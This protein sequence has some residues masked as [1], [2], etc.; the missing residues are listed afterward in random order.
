VPQATREDSGMKMVPIRDQARTLARVQVDQ[1]G[2][3]ILVIEDQRSLALL[4]ASMLHDRWGCTVHVAHTLAEARAHLAAESGYL[5]AICDLHLPDAEHGEVIDPVVR[6]GVPAIAVTAAFGDEMRALILK[7]GVVDYV[8]KD[9]INAYGY[10]CDLIGRLSRN[11]SIKVLAVDDSASIRAVLKQAL[12]MYSLQVLLASD[13]A[14]GLAL[15]GAHPEI[16]V[17]LVDCLMP[18]MDGF[19]LTIEARKLHGKDR[20]AIIGMSGSDD[21]MFSA[22]FLKNGANDF[23]RKPFHFEEVICRVNQN[24]EVLELIEIAQNAANRDFLTGLFNRRYF[25]HEGRDRYSSARG[26]R[27]NVAAAMLDLD[28]FKQ[29]NDRFGHER[30]DLVLRATAKCIQQAFPE[31]LPA[32]LGGEEFAILCIDCTPTTLVQRLERL[33]ENIAAMQVEACDFGVTVSMGL[34]TAGHPE[35]S[36][37]VMLRRAD[38]FLYQAKQGGRNRLVHDL[39]PAP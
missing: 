13:G 35:E 36:L 1:I 29:V 7:K 14:E 17:L 11:R 37:E 21:P 2:K 4:L 16:R 25:F 28:H 32:R 12:G 15:L 3:P 23:I 22:R 38:E 5:A 9:S 10:V 27:R 24:L 19:Q 31:Q 30:G 20:L 39:R 33:R 34:S 26:A 18:T 8:L 6:S